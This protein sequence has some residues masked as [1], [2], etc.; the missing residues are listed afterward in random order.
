M[1]LLAYKFVP[2]RCRLCGRLPDVRGE[3]VICRDA[4]CRLSTFRSRATLWPRRMVIDWRAT[5]ILW[6]VTTGQAL[7]MLSV[8]AT[9]CA[10]LVLAGG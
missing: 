8:L 1:Q 9:F 5:A 3:W 7:L 2:G 10:L 4:H 6:G